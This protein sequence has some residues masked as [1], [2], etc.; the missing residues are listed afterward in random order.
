LHQLSAN[1]LTTFGT[2]SG[3]Q[4]EKNLNLAVF[5]EGLYNGTGS[6]RKAQNAGGDQFPGNTADQFTI[7]LHNS[8]NYALVEYSATDV[9]LSTAGLASVTIPAIHGGSYYITIKHRNSIE[10]TTAAPVSFAPGTITYSFDAPL[11]AYGGNLHRMF[12][13]EY[14]IYGGDVNQDGIVGPEDLTGIDGLASIFASGYLPEDVN[15]DGVIDSND[16]VIAD[17]NA[18]IAISSVLP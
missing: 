8:S 6:M 15:G 2:F 11:K 18:S 13:G 3:V 1:G 10:T 9:N 14:A 17:N 16:L 4:A 12:T 5:L 7:A